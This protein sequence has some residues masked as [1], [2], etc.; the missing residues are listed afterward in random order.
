MIDGEG[1][2]HPVPYKPEIDNWLQNK[3]LPKYHDYDE[4]D[5][6][7]TLDDTVEFVRLFWP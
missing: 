1:Q 3:G 5:I 7:I 2:M 6:H 4:N